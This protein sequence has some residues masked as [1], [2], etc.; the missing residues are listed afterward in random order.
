MGVR[1]NLEEAYRLVV[2]ELDAS[3][4]LADDP[5]SEEARELYKLAK[6]A[7]AEHRIATRM[8]R[9][10]LF[11]GYNPEEEQETT[12]AKPLRSGNGM[13]VTLPLSEFRDLVNKLELATRSLRMAQERGKALA[14]ECAAWNEW[15]NN[16][17]QQNP[18]IPVIRAV[19][20]NKKLGSYSFFAD[21]VTE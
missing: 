1:R 11:S 2:A 21:E 17:A 19:K 20:L 13:S 6:A 3:Q 12:K 7:V 4:A 8:L 15:T 10:V 9:A 5:K 18:D 14:D 16:V